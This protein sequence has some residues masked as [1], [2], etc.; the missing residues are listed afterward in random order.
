MK[1]L[2]VVLLCCGAFIVS[3]NNFKNGNSTELNEEYNEANIDN[4][5]VLDLDENDDSNIPKLKIPKDILIKQAKRELEENKNYSKAL[6][7]F[8]KVLYA[9]IEQKDSWIYYEI[10]RIQIKL[11]N[12]NEAI[13]SFTKAIELENKAEYY[14]ARAEAY[15]LVG[16]NELANTDKKEA[17]KLTKITDKPD[18]II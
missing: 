13:E 3:C 10:G 7:L 5:Y 6:L 15:N 1:K 16:N 4:R 14:E 11:N 8:K 9:E 12:I 2:F 17:Q 18:V